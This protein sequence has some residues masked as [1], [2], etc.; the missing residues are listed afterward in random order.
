VDEDDSDSIYDDGTNARTSGE[1]VT[2][3]GPSQNCVPTQA[4]KKTVDISKI[5]KEV[6]NHFGWLDQFAH[7]ERAKKLTVAGSEGITERTKA[8]R[9]IFQDICLEVSRLSGRSQLTQ[10]QLRLMMNTYSDSLLEKSA[11]IGRL[12]AE[13]D[14]LRAEIQARERADEMTERQTVTAKPKS[15][16]PAQAATTSTSYAEKAKMD[17]RPD[18]PVKVPKSIPKDNSKNIKKTLTKCREAKTASRL[19]FEVPDNVTIAAAKAELWQT[20]KGKIRNPRARTVINGK[21]IIIIPDDDNTL[22]VV[23]NLPN[24]KITGPK[25]PRVIIYDVDSQLNG[26]EIIAGLIDQNPELGLTKSE[27]DKIVTKHKL[28]PRDGTTT[29]WVL[30]VPASVIPRLEGKLVFLGLTRCKIKIHQNVPQCFHCQG[31]GHTAIKCTQ[32]LPRCRHCAGLHD[33]RKCKEPQKAVCTNCKGDHK[34]S[35]AT[36]AHRIR[37][38]KSLLRRTDFSSK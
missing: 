13:N 24:V 30:E 32:E 15:A 17:P 34:A 8:L 6:N 11:V 2:D 7:T 37:A 22:E 29:H 19:S 18:Q 21:N 28:G 33:S 5:A 27:T 9:C 16:R 26:D 38:I 31:H 25:Q 3:E 1:M 10:D 35:S 12:Q 14:E 4:K 36:C 23:S 20:V